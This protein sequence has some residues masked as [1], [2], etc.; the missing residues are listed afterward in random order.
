MEFG[1]YQK[2]VTNNLL[3]IGAC[4]EMKGV[5]GSKSLVRW[6]ILKRLSAVLR[7]KCAKLKSQLTV[8]VYF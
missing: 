3:Q 7:L 5:G 8:N 6:Y 4:F 1:G 2:R